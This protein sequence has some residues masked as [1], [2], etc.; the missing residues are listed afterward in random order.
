MSD[1]YGVYVYDCPCGWKNLKKN[2]APDEPCKA[3]CK[4]PDPAS[5]NCWTFTDRVAEQ[6]ASYSEIQSAAIREWAE[7]TSGYHLFQQNKSKW[8][9]MQLDGP[10]AVRYGDDEGRA[11][12]TMRLVMKGK[13]QECMKFLKSRADK[14]PAHLTP[15]KDK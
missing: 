9:V 12:R 2:P 14:I 7:K 10:I 6:I 3:C 8:I 5:A 1:R 15:N 11:F 4:R 13:W